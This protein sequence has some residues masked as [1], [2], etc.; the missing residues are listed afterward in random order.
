MEF[1]VRSS[2]QAI[3]YDRENDVS[4]TKLKIIFRKSSEGESTV[5]DY[6]DRQI[7]RS[8]L[9]VWPVGT[10][11]LPSLAVLSLRYLRL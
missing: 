7:S 6:S 10:S 4:D 11:M 3:S 9:G 2:P 8:W 1:G 5:I